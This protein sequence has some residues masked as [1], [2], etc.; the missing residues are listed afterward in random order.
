MKTKSLSTRMILFWIFLNL[1]IVG[2]M[3]LAMFQQTTPGMENASFWKKLM[4]AEMWA[5]IEWMFIIPVNRLGNAFFTATQLSL[6]S[7][8]FNFIGQILTNLF[9]LKKPVTLDDYAAMVVILGAMYISAYK[10]LG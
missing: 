7:Y 9:W 3:D 10:I 4:W 5:S 1:C 2:L 8:V 6:S